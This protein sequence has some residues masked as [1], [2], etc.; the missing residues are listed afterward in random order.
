MSLI[1]LDFCAKFDI[2]EFAGHTHYAEIEALHAEV[3]VWVPD[4]EAQ[5]A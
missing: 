4:E 3:K 2:A 5:P 1:D